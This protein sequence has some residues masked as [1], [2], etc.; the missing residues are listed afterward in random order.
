M[1]PQWLIF[2][3]L[4][5]LLSNTFN[6]FNRFILRNKEDSTA[7]SWYYEFFRFLAFCAIAVV[8]DWQIIITTR[9]ILIFMLLGITETFSVYWYMKMHES[10][11]LSISTIL[12]RMRILWVPIIAF[13][14]LKENLKPIEYL[15]LLVLF[16]GVSVTV[17][18]HKFFIDKGAKYANLAAFM[19]A[20]NV[21]VTKIGLP[22][23]SNSLINAIC[24]FPSI[25]LF[26]LLMKSPRK[27]IS[28]YFHKNILLKSSVI[29]FNIISAYLLTQALRLGNPSKITGIY[30]SM[31]V[32]SVLAGIVILQEKKDILKKV[33]GASIVLAGVLL[34]G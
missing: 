1:L 25:F 13:F 27:R 6:F 8:F 28:V 31:M 3:V 7:Y 30:Q 22:Y 33:I 2:A 18:P 24:S 16:L 32:F 9:S 17:K 4:A 20:L 34:L 19:I 12:S 14:L 29:I 23:A 5:G 21:I 15:G 10:V 11:H 26:P